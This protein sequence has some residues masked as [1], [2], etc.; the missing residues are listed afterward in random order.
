MLCYIT[1]HYLT[2]VLHYA[3][4]DRIALQND[5]RVGRRRGRRLA[6]GVL[7]EDLGVA[8]VAQPQRVLT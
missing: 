5:L 6:R 4:L 2:S 7:A 8:E 1:L 3:A